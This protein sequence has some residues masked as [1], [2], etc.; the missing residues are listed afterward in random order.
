LL[1]P[2]S[3]RVVAGLLTEPRIPEPAQSLNPA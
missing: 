2:V 3:A 1:S